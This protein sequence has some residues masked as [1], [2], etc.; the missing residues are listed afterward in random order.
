MIAAS[1]GLS[2]GA[3]TNVI[4]EFKRGLGCAVVGDLMELGVTF[5][6]V[7]ITPAQCALGFRVAMMISKL[8]VKEDKDFRCL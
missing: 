4:N 2:V 5:K 7:G 1:T 3:V 8:G 6:K